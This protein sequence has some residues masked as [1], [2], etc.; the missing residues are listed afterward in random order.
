MRWAAMLLLLSTTLAAQN[1]DYLTDEE[2]DLIRDAQGLELR[3]P[4]FLKFADNRI[5][6]LGL[7]E[8]T[9]KERDQAKKD[10]ENYEREVKAASK[11]KDAEVRAKPVNPDVYLR[12]Y[13][14]VELLRGYAALL[15][16]LMDNIDDAFDRKLEVRPAVE[17]LDKFVRAQLPLLRK[18]EAK[19]PTESAAI[20]DVI[21][22]SER[23]AQEVRLALDKLPKT[24]R[25]SPQPTGQT[26]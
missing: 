15:D 4:A 5:V 23:T 25:R 21:K 11:V 1:F 24:E 13:N 20:E 7:R 18:F 16:E 8:R 26:R 17:E 3:A 9:A 6:A 14:R 22:H 19:T 12:Y 2:A 10:I